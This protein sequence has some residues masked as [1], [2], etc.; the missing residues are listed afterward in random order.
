MAGV[1][2]NI[3]PP[4]LAGWRGGGGSI[5]WKTPGTALDSTY[6]ST[7]WFMPISAQI[8]CV[9]YLYWFKFTVMFIINNVQIIQAFFIAGFSMG[10]MGHMLHSS[11]AHG[12]GISH[13]WPIQRR[14]LKTALKSD[15]HE[16]W[17][18]TFPSFC[19]LHLGSMSNIVHCNF[20]MN[21][22]SQKVKFT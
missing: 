6:V 10:P 15:K 5:F 7:L 8:A 12:H 18:W 22:R 3:D 4:T 16:L 2:Q 13:V 19:N 17:S 11:M 20:S 21:P 9:G 1:F 14:H